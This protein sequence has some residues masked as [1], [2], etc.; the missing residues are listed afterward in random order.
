MRSHVVAAAPDAAPDLKEPA[1][2][3]V[4]L[5]N[6]VNSVDV[7][8]DGHADTIVVAWR[9]NYNAHG[10]EA[11]TIYIQEP[12]SPAERDPKDTLHIVPIESPETKKGKHLRSEL[13]LRS[14]G[15]A[16]GRLQ[17]FRL[18]IDATHHAAVLI[19]ATRR[20]GE[21]YADSQPVTF[22]YFK[23]TRNEDGIPGWA[24]FRFQSYKKE[25][26]KKPYQDVNEAFQGELEIGSDGR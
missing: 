15:G 18:F 2:K 8:S 24:T 7:N 10:F 5:H 20:F 6:G 16:D 14:A 22:E 23:L 1:W 11:T 12:A 17:D 26:S 25:K 21:S 9:E 13:I 3:L 19:T 4:K